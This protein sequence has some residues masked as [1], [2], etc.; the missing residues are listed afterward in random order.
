MQLNRIKICEHLT[1]KIDTNSNKKLEEL[2]ER[3]L[4]SK[5]E[6]IEWCINKATIVM[7][8]QSYICQGCGKKY[9][10]VEPMELCSYCEDE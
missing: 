4:L 10:S 9:E 5:E 8:R 2:A 6:A 1:V 7:P 3:L